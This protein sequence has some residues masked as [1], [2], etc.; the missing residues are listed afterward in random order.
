[1][2]R[3][4]AVRRLLSNGYERRHQLYVCER[5]HRLAPYADTGIRGDPRPARSAPTPG[6]HATT[7]P[8]TADA[9]TE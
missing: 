2:T 5:R 6:S 4:V 1:M 9:A 3:I 7:R 8:A